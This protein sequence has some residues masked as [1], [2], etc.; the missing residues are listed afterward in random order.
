MDFMWQL[1]LT[2]HALI[3]AGQVTANAELILLGL[4]FRISAQIPLIAIEILKK[5][6]F[7]SSP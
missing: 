4:S 1:I 6:L 2:M 5:T 3:G 7:G